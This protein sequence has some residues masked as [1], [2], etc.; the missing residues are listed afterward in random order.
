M[1]NLSK[2]PYQGAL[3]VALLAVGN[4]ILDTVTDMAN[5]TAVLYVAVV[6]ISANFAQPRG[7][8]LTGAVCMAL[9]LLGFFF[10]RPGSPQAG[11]INGVISLSAIAASI[12]LVLRIKSAEIAEREAQSQLMHV[13]RL[14]V[15][16]ELTASI[17]HEVNQPLAGVVTSSNAGLR[18]L[19]ADPPN[20][21]RARQA[22]ERIVKDAN[23]AS[24]VIVRVR[25]LASPA[26]TQKNWL[27]IND[28]IREVI[29]LTLSEI[30]QHQISLRTQLAGDLPLIQGDQVQL[31]QVVLNLMMNAIEAM[32][33][34]EG[35]R[36]KLLLKTAN[37]EADGVVVMVADSG[38][39][40]GPVSPDR[41]FD[42]FY[43]TKPGGLGMGLAI[44]RSI[45]EAHG[46]SISAEA[47]KSA[48]TIIRVTLPVSWEESA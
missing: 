14:T 29:T 23:R 19:A 35:V 1:R 5:A 28:A 12:Y 2:R 7:V 38:S 32:T 40:F 44:S 8:V 25:N 11:L 37:T 41:L 10:S 22:I 39:G 42:A 16:G 30:E 9:T 21:A 36:R 46:G 4:F 48:G 3:I 33:R 20:V 13:A 26:P 45:I 34:T 18:W 27:S 15:L 47:N 17:A 24:E 6:L 31:Q 43:T